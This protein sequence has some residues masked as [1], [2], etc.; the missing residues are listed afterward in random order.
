MRDFGYNFFWEDKYTENIFALGSESSRADK[1]WYEAVTVFECFEHWVDPLSEIKQLFM[2][3]DTI[4]FTTNLIT[5]P[6]PKPSDWWYYGFDHGQHISFFSKKSLVVI[7]NLLGC[8]FFSKN[9]IHILAR[10]KISLFR[11][12]LASLK[13]KSVIYFLGTTGKNSLVY[14]D[15]LRLIN[16]VE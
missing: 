10:K 14:T 6:A 1:D 15:H 4:F 11:L 8:Y 5:T 16:K 12:F 9:G 7:S 3:T 13:A 2:K